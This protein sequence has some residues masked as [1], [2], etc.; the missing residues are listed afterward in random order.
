MVVSSSSVTVE[1]FAR[2]DEYTIAAWRRI[3]MLIWKSKGNAAGIEHSRRVFDEWVEEFQLGAVFL[4][5][6]PA[7]HA[8]PPD[9]K[10]RE[11]MRKAAEYHPSVRLKGMGTLIQA[12]GFVAASIR[13]IIMRL[14]V[15]TG[16]GAPNLFETANKAAEWA[17]QVL[18]DSEV[19]GIKLANAIRVAQESSEA[20]AAHEDVRSSL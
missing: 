9:A 20:P 4:V 17:S 15:L 11:A 5:V 12:E 10:T 3:L 1:V 19:S 6:V 2:T 7:R 13:S 14:D 8:D 16:K 18:G